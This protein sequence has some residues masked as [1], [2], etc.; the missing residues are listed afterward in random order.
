MV[1]ESEFCTAKIIEILYGFKHVIPKQIW[2]TIMVPIINT[3]FYIKI[4]AMQSLVQE[5]KLLPK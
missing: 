1:S 5:T 2:S 3:S 4:H